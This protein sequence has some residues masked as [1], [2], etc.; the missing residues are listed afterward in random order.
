MNTRSYVYWSVLGCAL[1]VAAGCSTAT[2]QKATSLDRASSSRS[3]GALMQSHTDGPPR[4][5]SK[6]ELS[7]PDQPTIEAWVRDFSSRKHKSF[8]TQLDRS[9]PYVKPTQEIFAD[10]GLPKDLIYVALVESGFTPKARSKAKAVGMWQFI[11]DTGRRFG[12]AQNQWV[13]ERC[14]PMKAARAAADYLSALY[15]QFGSWPLALAAYNCGENG[16][17]S[18]LDRTGLKTFW[19]LA[20]NGYLPAETRDYVPKVLA[21][22]KIVRNVQRYGFYLGTGRHA[23]KQETVSVPGGVKLAWVGKQIGVSED[24]LQNCNPELCK[25]VTPPGCTAYNLCV[26]EGAGE[27]VLACLVERA[28]EEQKEAFVSTTVSSS[29]NGASSRPTKSGDSRLSAARNRK[30]PVKEVAVSNSGKQ[31]RLA[32]PGQAP[33]DSTANS[34]VTVQAAKTKPTKDTKEAK[35][36]PA[37]SPVASSKSTNG[38]QKA[39]DNAQAAKR[40][41]APTGSMDGKARDAVKGPSVQNGPSPSQKMTS[42]SGLVVAAN[43]EEKLGSKKSSK[44]KAKP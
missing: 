21:T 24:V 27:S 5:S 23:S 40:Q 17:Q 29:S 11:P 6:S 20:D 37:P 35:G 30:G 2:S 31:S 41:P 8:Q 14:H 7:I 10:R 26:P 12:L 22:V 42:G 13:D 36:T 4:N 28:R 38:K 1:A 44:K 25:P 33:K 16:V 39:P 34:R 19:E 9:T 3:S 15:D 18:T 43:D 32:K